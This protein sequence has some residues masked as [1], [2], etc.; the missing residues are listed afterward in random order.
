MGDVQG[1]ILEFLSSQKRASDLPPITPDANL[2]EEGILD[3]FR[4]VEFVA[5]LE[6]ETGVSI[7]DEDLDDPRFTTVA[8]ILELLDRRGALDGRRQDGLP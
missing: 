6:K 2:F 8:G 5:F 3:S 4:L 7:P 1:K